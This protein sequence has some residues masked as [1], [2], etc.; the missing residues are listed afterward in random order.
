VRP[1]RRLLPLVVLLAACAAPDEAYSTFD[2]VIQCEDMVRERLK[3]PATARFEESVN[4]K[5]EQVSST[6]EGFAWAGWVDS[7]NSFGALV[8]TRFT[9]AYDRAGDDVSVALH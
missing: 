1:V 3:A 6:P 8:R 9:C 5:Q 2:L 7:E 4:A